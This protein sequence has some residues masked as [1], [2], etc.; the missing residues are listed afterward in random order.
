LDPGHH[1]LHHV[2][3]SEAEEQVDSESGTEEMLTKTHESVA[4]NGDRGL[5]EDPGQ[6]EDLQCVE[7]FPAP[8]EVGPRGPNRAGQEEQWKSLVTCAQK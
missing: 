4:K 1:A 3:K 6:Q 8:S 2:E 5:S 7:R